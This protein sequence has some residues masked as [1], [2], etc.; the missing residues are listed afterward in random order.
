VRDLGV[1]LELS[2]CYG[3]LGRAGDAARSYVAAVAAEPDNAEWCYQAAVWL[4]RDGQRG[5]A[6]TYAQHAATKGHEG[7]RKLVEAWK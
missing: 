5:R 6:E 4:D 3:M 2:Q 7:A 1:V